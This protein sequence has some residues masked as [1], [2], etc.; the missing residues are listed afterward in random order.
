MICLWGKREKVKADYL[1]E[2]LRK[3]MRTHDLLVEQR[4]KVAGEAVENFSA[5]KKRKRVSK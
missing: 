5:V 2:R 4:E 3:K 1:P